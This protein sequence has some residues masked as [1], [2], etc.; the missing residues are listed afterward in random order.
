MKI[1]AQ[2]A[3]I[4]MNG[5]KELDTIIQKILILKEKEGPYEPEELFSTNYGWMFIKQLKEVIIFSRKGLI[6]SLIFD[7]SQSFNSLLGILFSDDFEKEMVDKEFLKNEDLEKI[8]LLKS[9]F[10]EELTEEEVEVID[11]SLVITE[12][13]QM[14]FI[15]YQ[16]IANCTYFEVFAENLLSD[17]VDKLIE[18]KHGFEKK[19]KINVKDVIK[20]INRKSH[21]NGYIQ[22]DDFI[23]SIG[24]KKKIL[25]TLSE[26]KLEN[27]MKVIKEVKDLRNEIAHREPLISL[28]IFEQEEYANLQEHIK[29][30]QNVVNELEI[31]SFEKSNIPQKIVDLYV[32]FLNKFK[33]QIP[34]MSIPEAI[35]DAFITYS[36][37]ISESIKLYLKI[38]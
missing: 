10:E 18:N 21:L 25:H 15:S 6:Y 33:D 9:L 38:N 34:I 7:F 30:F 29:K 13:E 11:P 23:K 28:M 12:A 16:I 35:N 19:Y 20:K 3:C 5:W 14:A 31:P 26:Y 36:A 32:N 37:I 8:E 4:Q 2:F 24:I 17:I 1:D 27:L 22:I